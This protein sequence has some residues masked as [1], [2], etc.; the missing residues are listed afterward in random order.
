MARWC[1]L[2][3]YPSRAGLCPVPSKLSVVL[4]FRKGNNS[5]STLRIE[6]SGNKRQRLRKQSRFLQR[7]E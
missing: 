1:V 7:H 6:Y 5:T 4:I 3:S 2:R